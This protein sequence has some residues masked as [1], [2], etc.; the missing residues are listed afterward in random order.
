MDA[1]AR[2]RELALLGIEVR[3]HPHPGQHYKHGWIPVNVSTPSAKQAESLAQK[4]AIRDLEQHIEKLRREGPPRYQR[5]PDL[6]VETELHQ[7]VHGLPIGSRIPKRPERLGFESLPSGHWR[8]PATGRLHGES[9]AMGWD[10]DV[11]AAENYLQ[12]LKDPAYWKSHGAEA[13]AEIEALKR[14]ARALKM[15][16]DLELAGI[17]VR[18]TQSQNTGTGGGYAPPHVPAGSSK[19]GQFGTTAGTPTAGSGSGIG[20]MPQSTYKSGGGKAKSKASAPA[21]TPQPPTTSRTMKVGDSGE[22]VRYAQYAMNLLGFKVAQD[23]QYGPETE[24]AVK[25]MQ[26]RLGVA[27]PNGHLSPSMLHKMQDAVRLSPCIGAGQRDLEFE[28]EWEA[29]D[30]EDVDDDV[31]DED[32]EALIAALGEFIGADERSF[33][34][35]LHPRNPKGSVGGGRFRSIVDRV[36]DALDSWKKGDGPDDP[37]KDFNRDQL[38][39]AAKAHG[40]TFRRGASIEE[41]KAQIL[42]DVRNGTKAAKAE[43]PN[44]PGAPK[45][46]RRFTIQLGGTPAAEGK[47]TKVSMRDL[48]VGDTVY[49]RQDRIGEWYTAGDAKGATPVKLTKIGQDHYL[50][51][52]AKVL[53]GTAPNGEEIHIVQERPSGPNITMGMTPAH[54]VLVAPKGGAPSGTATDVGIFGNPSTGKL[55]LYRESDTGKRTGRAIKSFDDMGALE[56]WAR[57]NGHTELADY[58]KAE[59]AKT[60]APSAPAAKAAQA[61]PKTGRVTDQYR[62]KLI[63]G[64]DQMIAEAPPEFK[65]TFGGRASGYQNL[66][67]LRARLASGASERWEDFHSV[68]SS[69]NTRY[70][71]GT[72][73]TGFGGYDKPSARFLREWPTDRI[74]NG[75]GGVPSAPAAKKAAPNATVKPPDPATILSSLPV[76]LTPAQKRARLRSRGVPKEQIDALVPLKPRKAAAAKQGTGRDVT[77]DRQLIRQVYEAGLAD[78]EWKPSGSGIGSQRGGRFDPTGGGYQAHLALAKAQGFDVQPRVLHSDRPGVYDSSDKG[79]REYQ[80]LIDAGGTELYR[81]FGWGQTAEGG[82]TGE[83][84]AHEYLYGPLHVG[85][86]LGLGTNFSTDLSA[87]AYYS[88][89]GMGKKLPGGKLIGAVLP[90]GARVISYS[91]AVKQ[92][93]EFLAKLPAG[94]EHDAERKVFEDPGTFAMARGYDAMVA[95]HDQAKIVKRGTEEWVVFNR[96]KLTVWDDD[97]PARTKA[98]RSFALRALGHD[99]TPGHDE[100]HHYW[101]VGAGRQKWVHSPKPWTTLVALLTRHVGPEKAK[102]YA[103]RWFIEVK[104]YAAGSDLNRVAHGHPPRGHRIG[105]G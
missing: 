74:A 15:R 55:S 66:V 63:A 50:P 81:G 105:P 23:G 54:E 6:Y 53:K 69:L 104:G 7:R 31:P 11:L 39:K 46:H 45:D 4:Q 85:G 86:G 89:D 10:H 99:V 72:S 57:D 27:K 40:H 70:G 36:V 3:G 30:V 21:G 65:E 2:A 68:F 79:A 33:S 82:K 56:S 25:Q 98:A 92:R 94:P 84:M 49:A 59:Q 73:T 96:G 35:A 43:A 103:S 83:Q 17:E 93:D 13:A 34:E 24:A 19:G 64:L 62:Q 75:T 16:R 26:E 28:A 44:L 1:A 41:I 48:K 95:N 37:L 102:I 78:G 14:R 22:D 67:D 90:K 87:A 77:G 20:S 101:T 91:D 5:S 88:E 38:L 51:M 47:P 58:A 52:D 100:L 12:Q 9:A 8:D 71:S 80:R 32:T 61:A 18:A 76:D 97:P 29:R 60:G 42:D